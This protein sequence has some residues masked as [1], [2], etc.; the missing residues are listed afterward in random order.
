[1]ARCWSERPGQELPPDM[2]QKWCLEWARLPA[3]FPNCGEPALTSAPSGNSRCQLGSMTVPFLL[4][5]DDRSSSKGQGASYQ[6]FTFTVRSFPILVEALGLHIPLLKNL[7]T[8]SNSSEITVELTDSVSKQL[9]YHV[10]FNQS[11]LK[12]T[13]REVGYLY[14]DLKNRH[15]PLENFEGHLSLRFSSPDMPRVP[16]RCSVT[17]G[18]D[19]GVMGL[20]ETTGLLQSHN[21]ATLPFSKYACPLVSL[22]YSVLDPDTLKRLHRSKNQQIEMERLANK[23]LRKRA[24]LEEEEYGDI[25]NPEKDV[26]KKHVKP[27]A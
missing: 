27:N 7:A 16:R 12:T 22:Q 19:F 15:L 6:G 2:A 23:D 24:N 8:K 21:S 1:M 13:K 9:I 10:S 14:K 5:E 3:T 18:E 17:Y 25:A 11:D 26:T 20:I 4:P